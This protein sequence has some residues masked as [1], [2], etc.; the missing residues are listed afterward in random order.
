ML[1]DNLCN[2]EREMT[3]FRNCEATIP[4]NAFPEKIHKVVR[5]DEWLPTALLIMHIS[6]FC[7]LFAPATRH[8]LAHD[9]RTIDLAQLTMN[10]DQL[11]A[12][13]IQK[14]YHRPHFTVGESWNMS[15]HLHRCNDATLRTH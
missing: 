1:C 8:L 7:K 9:V 10:F 13:C 2:K 3:E 11:F 4:H 15:L 6:T 14:R 12:L 5:I